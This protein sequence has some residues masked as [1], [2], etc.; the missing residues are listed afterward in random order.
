MIIISMNPYLKREMYY[1]MAFA[2]A[3]ISAWK[4]DV[5]H[6]CQANLHFLLTSNY[7]MVFI[8]AKR[9]SMIAT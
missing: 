2:I 7:A 5:K 6:S 1:Q 8:I 3:L 4:C 9:T